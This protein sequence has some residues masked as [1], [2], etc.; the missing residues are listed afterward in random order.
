[1]TTVPILLEILVVLPEEVNN[2]SLRL[3][4]NQRT[5]WK[6]IL[7]DQC[8]GVLSMLSSCMEYWP[9]DEEIKIRVRRERW[10]M[11]C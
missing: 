10:R 1:M 6:T 2:R 5:K 8:S 3:G 9:N 4:E 11:R 7:G